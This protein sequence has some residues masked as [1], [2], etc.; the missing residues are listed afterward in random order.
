MRLAAL[1][2]GVGNLIVRAPHDLVFFKACGA[3]SH[4]TEAYAEIIAFPMANVINHSVL[5]QEE[6]SLN[7]C[8]AAQGMSDLRFLQR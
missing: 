7:S 3:C 5:V 4:F 1:V 8:I 2:C 6:D